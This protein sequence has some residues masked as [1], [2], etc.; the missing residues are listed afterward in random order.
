MVP[1]L[2]SIH[3]VKNE[4]Y[5]KAFDVESASGDV[6][7]INLS[8][9]RWADASSHWGIA[10]ELAAIFNLKCIF[11]PLK[12]FANKK[13][14]GKK[15]VKVEIKNNKLCPRYLAFSFNIS[16]I[17]D[18]PGWMQN[19]LKNCGLR[20][21]NAVVDIMN[22]IM[23]ET[24]QPL[25]A[26]DAERVFK[27][28]VVRK[29][30]NN[31][32]IVAI[33]GSEFNL[34]ESDLVIADYQKPL[35]IAGIKGGKTSEIN[36]NTKNIIVESANFDSANIYKTSKKIGL[37]TDASLRFSHGLSPELADIGI[38]RA[39]V[40]LREI[41]G[42]KLESITDIYPKK[43]PE[44]IL[45]FD[46]EKLNN[47]IGFEFDKKT[48]SDILQR[49]GFS[50]TSP[51]GLSAGHINFVKP[52]SLRTDINIFED[53]A[54]E[55]AR[56]YGLNNIKSKAPIV[57]LKIAETDT[58]IT[59]KEKIRE[60][61]VLVGFSEVYNYSFSEKKEDS[62]I[63]ILNPIS[64]DKK[65]LRTSLVS[66]LLKNIED[67]Y[68]F[69]D[70]IKIFEIGKVFEEGGKEYWKLAA[71]IYLRPKDDLRLKNGL[72]S[73]GNF[74]SENSL[75]ELKGVLEELFN[76]LGI[77]NF[78]FKEE[79]E[80]LKIFAGQKDLLG[81]LLIYSDKLSL[82]CKSVFEIDLEKL[83]EI[84]KGDLEYALI[85]PYPIIERD[86]SMYINEKLKVGLIFDSIKNLGILDIARIDI[87]DYYREKE[88][89]KKKLSITLRF[90]FQSTKQTLSD[91]EVNQKI[92]KIIEDLQS[93]FSVI[94]R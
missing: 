58:I 94:I 85:S 45:K 3:K 29:A 46:L 56:I 76:R 53:L 19:I 60:I 7:N 61:M 9:N 38:K 11:N 71:G 39:S 90:V 57:S 26:F 65:F 1:G 83:S 51:A 88:D 20:P 5:L 67:N 43:R 25:H 80:F 73:K 16:K 89:E 27:G 21:I 50:L 52:P 2:P 47:L 64:R 63:E 4:L 17:G 54:E 40:L 82:G 44:I 66:G 32:K 36:V 55:V 69:F 34:D 70:A 78:Y 30:K 35:A 86:V 41:C 12:G 68:R 87:V 18:S 14:K 24:G 31:E 79:G 62:S 75:R 33:D 15:T 22:Y 49:L 48:V 8:P 28:I 23:L 42:A 13:L 93:K 84:Y 37:K 72:W 59:L 91:E 92:S 10:K 6:I 81:N 74:K 77:K